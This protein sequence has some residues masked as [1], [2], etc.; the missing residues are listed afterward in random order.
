MTVGFNGMISGGG[1]D[2]MGSNCTERMMA[3]S[4]VE[5]DEGGAALWEEGGTTLLEEGGATVFC[6]GL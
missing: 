1:D 2:G 4:E 3:S 6:P 5:L